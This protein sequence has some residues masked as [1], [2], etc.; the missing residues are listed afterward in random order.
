MNL[1]PIRVGHSKVQQNRVERLQRPVKN[2]QG[3]RPILGLRQLR[4]QWQW[5]SWPDS[6]RHTQAH[7]F[8]HPRVEQHHGAHVTRHLAAY[9]VKRAYQ[10]SGQSKPDGGLCTRSDDSGLPSGSTCGQGCG[11]GWRLEGCDDAD[12]L[13]FSSRTRIPCEPWWSTPSQGPGK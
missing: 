4:H 8:P 2:V 5:T 6:V 1:H 10:L 9:W 13:L 12:Q 3:L 11:S 7:V